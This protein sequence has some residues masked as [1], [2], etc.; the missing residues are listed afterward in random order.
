MLNSLNWKVQKMCGAM[1]SIGYNP[2]KERA[3]VSKGE[4]ASITCGDGESNGK[5]MAP[6]SGAIRRCRGGGEESTGRY[7][8]S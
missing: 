6:L 2:I 1:F 8:V 5:S 7:V 4:E 3:T